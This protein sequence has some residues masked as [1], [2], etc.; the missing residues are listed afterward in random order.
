MRSRVVFWT[1]GF[2]G[3]GGQLAVTKHV[4]DLLKESG[5]VVS[6]AQYKV[7]RISHIFRLVLSILKLIFH[8]SVIYLPASRS[9][10]GALRDMPVYLL[11]LFGRKLV[12]HLHGN[13]FRILFGYR[14]VGTFIRYIWSCR[15]LVVVTNNVS[16][17]ELHSFGI[18]NVAVIENYFPFNVPYPNGK[19]RK[20]MYWNSNIIATKG[21]FEF[22]EAFTNLEKRY[23]Y[24]LIISGEILGC[25]EMSL[26]KTKET[27]YQ[28]LSQC[29]DITYTGP[30]SR[31]ETVDILLESEFCVLTSYN[32]SQPLSLIDGL[33]CGCEILC[34]DIPTLRELIAEFPGVYFVYPSVESINNIMALAISTELG[35]R[36]SDHIKERLLWQEEFI[37]R[38]STSMFKNRI[39]KVFRKIDSIS[40]APSEP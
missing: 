2:E 15:A 21:I 23:G 34:T 13:D 26:D 4:Y 7:N 35:L 3:S 29:R 14:L 39:L 40:S 1:Y 37:E 17:E 18:N 19:R 16:K 22:L 38:F 8:P 9:L 30:L 36:N 28:Y 12:I 27:L 20:Q 31:S 25:S 10:V 5:Y 32:E 24:K 6:L 33:C 11:G